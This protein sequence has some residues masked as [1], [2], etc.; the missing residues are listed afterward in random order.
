MLEQRSVAD[1]SLGE[2]RVAGGMDN[3]VAAQAPRAAH[4]LEHR[5]Q[6]QV[7]ERHHE[8][9]RS[10]DCLDRVRLED[11]RPLGDLQMSREPNR[12]PYRALGSLVVLDVDADDP[13]RSVVEVEYEGHVERAEAS[14]VGRIETAG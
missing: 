9:V 11:A 5:E 3:H 2:V 6:Q 13:V 12:L 10:V 8:Q 1:A 4:V 7:L 14:E